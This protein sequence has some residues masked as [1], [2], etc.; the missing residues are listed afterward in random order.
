MPYV[1]TKKGM[2][3]CYSQFRAG[4]KVISGIIRR[5]RAVSLADRGFERLPE[6]VI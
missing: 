6:K 4:E 5:E 1:I 3:R 2:A